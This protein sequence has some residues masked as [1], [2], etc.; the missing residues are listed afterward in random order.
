VVGIGLLQAVGWV[1]VIGFLVAAIASA[2][3]AGGLGLLAWRAFR[4]RPAAA[5]PAMVSEGVGVAT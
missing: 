5:A 2:A 3:G 4:A 1:P